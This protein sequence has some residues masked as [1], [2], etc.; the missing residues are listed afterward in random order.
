[1]EKNV[2]LFF[3]RFMISGAKSNGQQS[4]EIIS[5]R[6][7]WVEENYGLCSYFEICNSIERS[8]LSMNLAL[9]P[10]L[11]AAF[12]GLFSTTTWS[13]GKTL[14]IMSK[15]LC[16]FLYLYEILY[17]LRRSLLNVWIAKK[18]T[19]RSS[20]LLLCLVTFFVTQTL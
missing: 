6:T 14:L 19:K 17:F 11:N 4:K 8:L 16:Y 18:V 12:G 10:R 9:D 15:I 5:I 1:M 20:V 2:M 7:G 13:F 3:A